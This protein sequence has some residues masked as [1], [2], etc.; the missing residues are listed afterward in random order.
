[1][2]LLSLTI[3][4]TVARETLE[5]RC[6]NQ[7]GRDE[8]DHFN[9]DI[10]NSRFLLLLRPNALDAG[11]LHRG[12]AALFRDLAVLV[13]DGLLGRLVAVEAAEQLR[14]DAAVGALRAVHISDVEK[15]EFAFGIGT[16]FLGHARLVDAAAAGVKDIACRASMPSTAP[17]R[18]LLRTPAA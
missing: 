8:P 2:S 15:G 3:G 11:N 14:G 9:S 13:G 16:G 12:L 18:T 6:P 1:V 17:C 7:N 4:V 5:N 10:A